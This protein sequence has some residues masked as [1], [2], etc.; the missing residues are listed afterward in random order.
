MDD[1][2]LIAGLGNPGRDYKRTRHNAGFVVV[3]QFCEQFR[4]S[5]IAEKR[6]TAQVAR[7]NL[8]GRAVLLCEP[9][10]FMNVSGEAVEKLV[11]FFR[12]PLDR[13]IAVV[14][15]AD[16]PLGQIRLRPGGSSGGSAAAVVLRDATVDIR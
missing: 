5:W 2:Y 1:L 16:L 10:T 7:V 12:I 8:N 4:G 11:S 15:D 13:F 6:F 3:D 14:D 9:L